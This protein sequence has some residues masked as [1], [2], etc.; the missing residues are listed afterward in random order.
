MA[1]EAGHALVS[2]YA[3]DCWA[4]PLCHCCYEQAE[5]LFGQ[6]HIGVEPV[7]GDEVERCT[8]ELGEVDEE[9]AGLEVDAETDDSEELH[10]PAV[11]GGAHGVFAIVERGAAERW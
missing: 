5:V 9:A 8:D 1:E 3:H 7:F 10:A 4:P 6:G 2:A 11:F